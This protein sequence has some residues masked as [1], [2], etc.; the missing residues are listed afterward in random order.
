MIFTLM[1]AMLFSIIMM[2]KIDLML[3]YYTVRVK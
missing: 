3:Q 2:T 1:N